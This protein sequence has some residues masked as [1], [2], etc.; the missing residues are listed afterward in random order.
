MLGVAPRS[1]RRMGTATRDPWPDPVDRLQRRRGRRRVGSL[2]RSGTPRPAARAEACSSVVR[3]SFI[4]RGWWRGSPVKRRVRQR[5]PLRRCWRGRRRRGCRRASNRSNLPVI[6]SGGSQAVS[7][8]GS[9]RAAKTRSSGG[10]DHPR[11]R[12]GPCHGTILRTRHRRPWPVATG[13]PVAGLPGNDRNW[14]TA[15]PST[16]PPAQL[17]F[18]WL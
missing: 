9:T 12:V 10:G 15:S 4:A 11:G 1:L 7:A 14:S 17:A 2:P 18:Q 13:A 6:P 8:S 5:D 16:T 3:A